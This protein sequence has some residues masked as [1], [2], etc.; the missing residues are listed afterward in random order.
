[1]AEKI[2]GEYTMLQKALRENYRFFPITWKEK[3]QQQVK[4][5]IGYTNGWW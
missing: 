4:D 1:M 5:F 2:V 3:C